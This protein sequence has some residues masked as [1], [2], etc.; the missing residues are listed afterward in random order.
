[1]KDSEFRLPRY[2]FKVHGHGLAT[3]GPFFEID[4]E[5]GEWLK[6]KDV[7][8]LIKAYLELTNTRNKRLGF[9]EIEIVK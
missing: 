4:D 6:W 5:N 3:S 9:T 7:E 2:N 1:M 8:P